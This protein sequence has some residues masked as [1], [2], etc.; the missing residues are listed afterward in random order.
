MTD[1]EPI[2]LAKACELFPHA[3][4]TVSTLRAEAARGRLSIFRIGR[5]DYTT[6]MAMKR[7]VQLCH[8]EA[9]GRDSTCT[10]KHTNG[11]LETA[12][13]STAQAALKQSV[14]ALKQGLP[15]ISPKSIRRNDLRRH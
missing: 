10:V 1:D 15:R 9:R 12:Q 7:M 3:K 5:R 4:L 14:I 6:L 13:V 8:V 2:T 11:L